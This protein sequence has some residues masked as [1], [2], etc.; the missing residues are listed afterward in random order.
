MQQHHVIKNKRP[1]S[2]SD[3]SD[4]D[5]LHHRRKPGTAPSGK[6]IPLFFCLAGKGEQ[7][8]RAGA[9]PEATPSAIPSAIPDDL[10]APSPQATAT[11]IDRMPSKPG[12]TSLESD[13]VF[14]SSG[15]V[16][17]KGTAASRNVISDDFS[18]PRT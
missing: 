9:T 6:I 1:I 17:G 8:R 3:I 11:V 16:R 2:S 12:N 18:T 15:K 4:G 5:G 13:S 14:F 7:Q 10:S